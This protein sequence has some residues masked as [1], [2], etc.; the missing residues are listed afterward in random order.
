MMS[1]YAAETDFTLTRRESLI[2]S[3]S[4]SL[5]VITTV[6]LLVA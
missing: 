2:V 5:L 4:L 3:S 1:P 6:V